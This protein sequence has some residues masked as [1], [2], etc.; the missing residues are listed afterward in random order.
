MMLNRRVLVGLLSAAAIAPSRALSQQLGNS[1][2]KRVR[3][4]TLEIAYE[5]SGPETGFPVLLL[6][7]FPYDPRCYDEVV[8]PLVAAGYR[9][10]VPYLRG[11]GGTRFLAPETLRS[12]QQA[13]FGQD[14]LDLMDALNLQRA[15][16]VGYDWGGR[17]ASVVAALWPERVRCAVLANYGIFPDIVGSLQPAS[18]EQEHRFWYQF[19]FNTERGRAG[20]A[21]NRREFCKLLWQLWSPNWKFDDATYQRTAVS[22]DNPDFVDVVIHSYSH[23]FGN[24][25]SDPGLEAVERRAASQPPISVPTIVIQGGGDGVTAATQVD[26]QAH[27]FT[28]SYQ[29]RLIPIIGHNFP[30]EAP[31][32]TAA[33]VLELLR[34]TT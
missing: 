23:R 5:D 24:A 11:Y 31:K 1:V 27:F 3:A 15:S 19:Y 21:A 33:A 34:S 30:Q 29:R 6:H 26:T 16:L 20:L 2:L 13:A 25:P 22:F 18:P 32:E 7:G 10:F 12:G 9:A 4:G 8:P 28:G 17:A 14:V